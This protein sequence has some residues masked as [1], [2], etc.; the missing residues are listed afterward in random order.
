MA[1]KGT[2]QT[3]NGIPVRCGYCLHNLG[4][5]KQFGY[6]WHCSHLPHC[7]IFGLRYCKAYKEGKGNFELDNHKYDEWKKQNNIR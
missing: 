1:K 7:V 2:E 6:M 3:K 4:E 5:N